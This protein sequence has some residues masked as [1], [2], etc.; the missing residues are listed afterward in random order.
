[1]ATIDNAAIVKEMYDA[2]NSKDLDRYDSLCAAD[3][4]MT[5]VPF[6][7]K[8]APRDHAATF[9]TAFPDGRIE[10]TNFVSQGEWVVAEFTGRGTH[11]G[12]FRSPTSELPATHRRAELAFIEVFRCR[13]GKVVE[14]RSYFDFGSMLAQLGV[15]LPWTS[16]ARPSAQAPQ[17]R[18]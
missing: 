14:G 10:P 18:H 9:A 2:F 17:P 3:A 5:I 7:V 15:P 16:G 6:G 4:R 11:T 8:V 1:M 13:N 12:T